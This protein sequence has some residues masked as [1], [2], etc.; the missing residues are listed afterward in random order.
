MINAVLAH[1]KGIN[2]PFPPSSDPAKPKELGH[3]VVTR[4]L[5]SLCIQ[6]DQQHTWAKKR[7]RTHSNLAIKP[8]SNIHFALKRDLFVIWLLKEALFWLLSTQ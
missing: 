2:D 7:D 5:H 6:Q 1:K 8:C 3:K 4:T